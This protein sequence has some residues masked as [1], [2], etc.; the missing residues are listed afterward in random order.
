MAPEQVRG[1]EA[2]PRSD[3]FSFGCV[4]C[5]MVSGRAAF[6]GGTAE[7]VMSAILRADPSGLPIDRSRSEEQPRK[8][9][10]AWRK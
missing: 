3:I 6:A 1:E 2:D 4:L 9:R 10:A 8:R 5:E 7:D